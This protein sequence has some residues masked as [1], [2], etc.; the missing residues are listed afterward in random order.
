MEYRAGAQA[1]AAI[2][3]S[4]SRSRAKMEWLHPTHITAGKKLKGGQAQKYRHKNYRHKN[5]QHENY[6]ANKTQSRNADA[7]GD[8]MTPSMRKTCAK[9]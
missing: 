7:M 2:L 6:V 4:W 9:T 5:Y 3:T 1:G 8:D